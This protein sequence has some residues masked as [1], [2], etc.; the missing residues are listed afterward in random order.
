MLENHFDALQRNAGSTFETK[1][2]ALGRC[3]EEL[4]EAQRDTIRLHYDDELQC[5]DI[6]PQLGMGVE[7]VKKHLQ[8]FVGRPLP[9]NAAQIHE[10][11]RRHLRV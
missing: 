5:K 2:D 6:A 11:R 8:C 3:M 10:R 7:A 9:D 1:L 4:S